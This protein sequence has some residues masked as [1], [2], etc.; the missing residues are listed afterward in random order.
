MLQNELRIF[1]SYV[2]SDTKKKKDKKNYRL[3]ENDNLETFKKPL[4]N[5]SN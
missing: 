3:G 5:S 2:I 4:K 1:L